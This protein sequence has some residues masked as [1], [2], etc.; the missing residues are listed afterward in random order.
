M[1]Y[2]RANHASI[3][4]Q[5]TVYLLFGTDPSSDNAPQEGIE[6]ISL[7]KII[8]KTSF[9]KLVNQFHKKSLKLKPL[10]GILPDPNAHRILIFGKKIDNDY[11]YDEDE[12][13][14]VLTMHNFN[15]HDPKADIYKD[16][17]YDQ[18]KI[19]FD[20]QNLPFFF[21]GVYYVFGQDLSSVMKCKRNFKPK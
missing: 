11:G 5:D 21:K 10:Y 20:Q 17:E 8:K 2:D 19:T 16:T 7:S 9:W 1:Y 4:C 18:D 14:G 3:W 12:D 6:Y 13:N 15:L